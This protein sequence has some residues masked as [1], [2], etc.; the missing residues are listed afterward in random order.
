[1]ESKFLRCSCG[2]R[3]PSHKMRSVNNERMCQRCAKYAD[4]YNK[5]ELKRQGKCQVVVVLLDGTRLHFEPIMG[6]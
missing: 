4:T 3:L 5:R 1:M 6:G 2:K